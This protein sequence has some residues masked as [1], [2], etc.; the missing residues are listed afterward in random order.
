MIT[1]GFKCLHVMIIV[2]LKFPMPWSGSRWSELLQRVS[3]EANVW[4]TYESTVFSCT[5][6]GRVNVKFST[7]RI[8]PLPRQTVPACTRPP[9]AEICWRTRST[10]SNC[11][12]PLS[13]RF[14]FLFLFSTLYY[15]NLRSR[16]RCLSIPLLLLPLPCLALSCIPLTARQGKV[17]SQEKCDKAREGL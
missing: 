5:V 8:T 11:L 9:L 7:R 15:V 4:A 14:F 10:R 16:A 12:F 13:S 17:A 1:F 3:S 6:A 2:A